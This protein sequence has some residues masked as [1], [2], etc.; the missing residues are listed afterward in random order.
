MRKA[1][2]EIGRVRRFNGAYPLTVG[3][4]STLDNGK[5]GEKETRDVSLTLTLMLFPTCSLLGTKEDTATTLGPGNPK[6][7]PVGYDYDEL[8]REGLRQTLTVK[9][10]N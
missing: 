4:H 6:I 9:G 8:V 3:D 2:S 1:R 10:P 5:K 7:P